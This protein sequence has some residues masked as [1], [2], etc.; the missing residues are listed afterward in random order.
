MRNGA[1]LAL[2]AL[3]AAAW[4]ALASPGA[5]EVPVVRAP[6]GPAKV[7]PDDPGGLKVP[8]GGQSVYDLLEP[9]G[10]A[11]KSTAPKSA[12]PGGAGRFGAP[13]KSPTKN[14]KR[15]QAETPPGAGPSRN[16]TA[17]KIGPYR[18]QLGS[19]KDPATAQRRW[20]ALKDSHRDLLGGLSL[21]LE[22]ADLGPRGTYYRIQAGPLRT[23]SETKTLCAQ[24][25]ERKVN[26]I[27]VRS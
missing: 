8:F 10:T 13:A 15:Q 6:T 5:A 11:P 16:G 9:G 14:V 12:G 23:A 24:L 19:Y 18:I 7:K 17:E 27:L 22:K 2:L 20:Q 21:V 4:A 25:A 3:S 26:C 1:F